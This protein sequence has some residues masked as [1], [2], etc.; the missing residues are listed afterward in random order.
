V[1]VGDAKRAA[2]AL[3]DDLARYGMFIVKRGEVE[4]WLSEL[5]APPSKH[6]W[7]KGIFEK[8]GSDPALRAYV[9][10]TEGDVWAFMGEVSS[11]IGNPGRA[12]MS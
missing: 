3:L 6:L 12:G 11:W 8:M 1:L 2:E 10:P 9:R 7:L 5:G 4:A